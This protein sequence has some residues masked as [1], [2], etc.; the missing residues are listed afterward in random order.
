M[1]VVAPWCQEHAARTP[2]TSQDQKTETRLAHQGPA[3]NSGTP[4]PKGSATSQKSTTSWR[5]TAQIQVLVEGSL[6][7]SH[8]GGGGVGRGQELKAVSS[9]THCPPCPPPTPPLWSTSQ[10]LGQPRPTD[11]TSL[12]TTT[13][14]RHS[15]H[16]ATRELLRAPLG[17]LSTP[18]KG[19]PHLISKSIASE[20]E[21]CLSSHLLGILFSSVAF[22][23]FR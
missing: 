4:P 20:A 6:Y 18:L 23:G 9:N 16:M 19:W 13:C 5:P 17:P 22:R 8:G 3:S 12:N 10:C 7:S 21:G 2:P 14:P 15:T 11:V 1:A